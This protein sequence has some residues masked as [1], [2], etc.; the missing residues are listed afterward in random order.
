MDDFSDHNRVE[1]LFKLLEPGKAKAFRAS[2]LKQF[3]D[4]LAFFPTSFPFLMEKLNTYLQ[5]ESSDSRKSA[6]ECVGLLCKTSKDLQQLNTTDSETE[7]SDGNFCEFLDGINLDYLADVP[8]LLTDI[9][10]FSESNNTGITNTAPRRRPGSR[11]TATTF[12]LNYVSIV[13][14][15]DAP[16]LKRSKQ[17]S[18]PQHQCLQYLESYTAKIA[19][20]LTDLGDF[21]I[22]E[23]MS[24]VPLLNLITKNSV[25]DFIQ[26]YLENMFDQ[27]WK[28]R[29]GAVLALSHIL[30]KCWKA[31]GYSFALPSHFASHLHQYLIYKISIFTLSLIIVDKFFDFSTDM[32]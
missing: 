31:L 5:H 9:P 12:A 23:P 26:H 19:F 16:P 11:K 20:P 13:E 14:D 10:E 17:H 1:K 3:C 32:V 28:V 6:A 21:T 24:T 8:P 15:S 22:P 30:K 18:L 2:A 27:S 4:Y 7:N 29:H 25:E